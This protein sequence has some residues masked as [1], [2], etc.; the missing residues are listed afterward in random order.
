M[1]KKFKKRNMKI[2]KVRYY[3]ITS[4]QT[5]FII[6]GLLKKKLKQLLV[7]FKTN[8]KTVSWKIAE[9]KIVEVTVEISC[10]RETI[11]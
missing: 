1:K 9:I 10:I 7:K 11:I 4:N 6:M 3:Q 5:A 8:L 2:E